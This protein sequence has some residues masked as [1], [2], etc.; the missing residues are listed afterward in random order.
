MCT[1]EFWYGDLLEQGWEQTREFLVARQLL[2]RWKEGH[3]SNLHQKPTGKTFFRTTAVGFKDE[4][5]ALIRNDWVRLSLK[6]CPALP[7]SLNLIFLYLR[8]LPH[9]LAVSDLFF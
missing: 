8:Q 5:E 6:A 4:D 7:H 3:G 1:A 2:K 9:S